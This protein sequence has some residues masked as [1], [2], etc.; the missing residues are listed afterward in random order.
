MPKRTAVSKRTRFSVFARD[1]FTCRYCGRQ[2]DSVVLV[3]DHLI[4]V[5]AG[6]TN[7]M[8]NLVT[9][10]EPCNQGKSDTSLTQHAPNETDRLARLQ[11]QHEQLRVAQAAQQIAEARRQLEQ[12]VVN[13]W[14]D[15]RGTDGMQPNVARLMAGWAMRYGPEVVFQWIDIAVA[16]MAPWHADYR[17]ARYISGIRRNW[18]AAG[19]IPEEP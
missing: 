5:A 17:V 13:Y 1:N 6:G 11:E 19:R 12:T 18:I 10:C 2:S 3:I 16:S 15:A 4:P 9:A 14:C 7:D 8:E